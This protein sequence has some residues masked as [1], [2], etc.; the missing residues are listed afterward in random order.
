MTALAALALWLTAAPTWTWIA[1][2]IF[3]I[4]DAGLIA[5]AARIDAQ[6]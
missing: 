5:R 3:V 6:R 2:A 4:I 1:L